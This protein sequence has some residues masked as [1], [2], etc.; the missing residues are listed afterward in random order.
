[1]TMSS[2]DKNKV[3]SNRNDLS[4]RELM[5]AGVSMAMAAG[6]AFAASVSANRQI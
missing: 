4:R 6:G 1:M 5:S 2:I 3:H